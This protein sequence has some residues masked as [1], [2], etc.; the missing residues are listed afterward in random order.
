MTAGSV[1]SIERDQNV[2]FL[3]FSSSAPPP[4]LEEDSSWWPWT[5][6]GVEPVSGKP[7]TA[8]RSLPARWSPRPVRVLRRRFRRSQFAA[9]LR[10]Y[11]WLVGLLAAAG[12][13]LAAGEHL[14]DTV[15]YLFGGN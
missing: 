4:V 2:V 7:A 12:L 9:D 1:V 14:H 10:A 3:T 5:E 8:T 6:T 13:V 15:I 11:A